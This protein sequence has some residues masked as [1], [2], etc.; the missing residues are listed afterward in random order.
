MNKLNCTEVIT[1]RQNASVV[2]ACKLSEKKYRDAEKKFR[3]D[4]VKLFEEVLR[5][6]AV[7]ESVFLCE[8]AVNRLCDRIGD[9]LNCIPSERI[10]VVSDGV[11]DKM[12][13]EKSPEGIICVVKHIDKLHKIVKMNNEDM[14]RSEIGKS[15]IFAVESVRDPG[16]MGTIIRTAAAFGVDVLLISADCADLYNPRTVRAAMGALFRQKI[17]R[18]DEFSSAIGVLS[19]GGRKTYAAT[20]G[21]K[22]VLLGENPLSSLD[23]IVVGNEGHGLSET[24]VEACDFNILIPMSPDAESLNAAVAASGCMWE[25]FGKNLKY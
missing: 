1:S 16:N 17:V 22:A 14:L 10:K 7:V 3:V 20:L 4:G 15:K 21:Q 5:S 23:C 13:E 9:L 8:S 6:E 12:T 18:A 19:S 25:Q 24:T 11:F 2:A